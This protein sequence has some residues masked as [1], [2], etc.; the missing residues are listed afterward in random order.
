MF[1]RSSFS[2]RSF[3]P[4]SWHFGGG[5]A[6]RVYGGRRRR[7]AD[8]SADAVHKHWDYLDDLR[9][10]KTQPKPEAPARPEPAP[11]PIAVA[12]PAPEPVAPPVPAA[13]LALL[14]PPAPAKPAARPPA[15]APIVSRA[16]RA[17]PAPVAPVSTTVPQDTL[18]Q[19]RQLAAQMGMAD[20]D[21]CLVLILA[22]LV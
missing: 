10:R 6:P 14:R 1:S 5:A 2:A 9:A 8:L 15:P 20:D 21:E 17:K 13:V 4:Q 11:E 3:S 22:A 16:P 12:P 7:D 19:A 18:L